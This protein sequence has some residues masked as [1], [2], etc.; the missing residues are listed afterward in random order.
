MPN[1]LIFSPYLDGHRQVYVYVI[2]NILQQLGFEI[3]IVGNLQEKISN[4][5]YIDK[6]KTKPEITIIDTANYAG[7]GLEI[8]L[9]DFLKIQDKCKSDLTI[10]TEADHHFPLFISQIFG[11]KNKFRGRVVGIF[12]RPFYF[13]QN[14]TLL[15]MLR[16]L[17]HFP[18]R[19]KKD[20]QFFYDFF[21]ARFRL[22]DVALCIDENFVSRH[23][24]FKWL[25]DVFQQ[26]AELILKTEENSDQRSWIGKLNAFTKKDKSR[27][28]FLYFG[29]AQYRRGYDLV[30]KLAEETGGCFVHCGLRDDDKF[31]KEIREMRL[32]LADSERL[33]ETNE[34]IDDPL[35]IEHFFKSVSHLILPYR[36]YFGSSGVML[37]ALSLGIPVLSPEDGIIGK[38]I[39][40]YRLG[41]T[42]TYKGWL[43]F[44]SQFESFKQIDPKTFAEDIHTY[45]NF[46]T[47]DQLKKV[48]INSFTGS[49]LR[50][51]Q[52]TIL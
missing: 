46:Q 20:E 5:V 34:Y 11:K 6:L 9:I 3:Y 22:L 36:S 39:K 41:K 16:F 28:I 51:T 1:A 45:M 35:T 12:M 14:S 48:L 27:F 15:G 17:K 30:L 18:S 40:N 10:F 25:P 42:Y 37:Q 33:F 32:H 26:Y 21:L 31:D 2:T 19:W 50:I 38:R 47:T 29:T 7:G 4:S 52:P 8:S 23:H 13:Y 44:K 24:K 43:S 49:N